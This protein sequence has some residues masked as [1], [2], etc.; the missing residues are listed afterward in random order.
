MKKFTSS[1]CIQLTYGGG[2]WGVGV[3]GGGGGGGGGWGG[4][5]GGWG[6]G[7][8]WGGGG[9]GESES[10]CEVNLLRIL[11]W[12]PKVTLVETSIWWS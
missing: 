12:P 11:W 5:G 4:G 6:V 7:V 9:K 10:L 2:G 1:Y 8:G 3:G